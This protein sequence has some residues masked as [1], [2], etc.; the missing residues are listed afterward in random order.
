MIYSYTRVSTNKQDYL[1]QDE[2]IKKW[3]TDNNMEIDVSF[4]DTITGKTFNRDGYNRMKQAAVSGDT[5]IIKELDRLGRDWDGIKEEWKYF[6]DKDINIVVIDMPLLSQAIYD[7]DGNID[8]NIK[9][10]KAIVFETLCYNAE[11]ERQKNSRRT[12]EK[13]QAMKAEG[14]KLGRPI[15]TEVDK[16]VCEL[17]AQGM[18]KSD[19]AF[20]AGVSRPQ[21]YAI[22]KRNHLM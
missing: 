2:A 5:I 3:C 20:Y 10:L 19:I 14:I 13:L 6:D 7:K 12:S 1:R 16:T 4:S 17:Y 8:L 22:L 15:N 21:V 9:F 11:L 18:N